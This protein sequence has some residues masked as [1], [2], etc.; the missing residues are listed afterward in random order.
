MPLC[1]CYLFKT[2]HWPGYKFL[3]RAYSNL[4]EPV[5]NPSL[6]V[7]GDGGVL[8][9]KEQAQ[10]RLEAQIDMRQVQLG[11]LHAGEKVQGQ[12]FKTEWLSGT[13][14]PITCK[15]A[16]PETTSYKI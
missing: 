12:R 8:H 3:I 10:V 4:Q 13:I 16:L 14:I 5:E 9:F 11:D 2:S 7:E 6:E 1:E 15:S